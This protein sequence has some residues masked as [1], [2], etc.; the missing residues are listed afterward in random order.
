MDEGFSLF[1]RS[2]GV[3]VGQMGEARLLVTKRKGF[4]TV[5]CVGFPTMDWVTTRQGREHMNQMRG[6]AH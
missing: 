1:V 2:Q 6:Q 3:E 4:L 5:L